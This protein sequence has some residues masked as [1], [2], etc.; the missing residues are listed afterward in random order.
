MKITAPRS[1]SGGPAARLTATISGLPGVAG[2]MDAWIEVPSGMAPAPGSQ[3]AGA[4]SSDASPWLVA[5]LPSAVSLQVPLEVEGRVSPRL[6]SG[7][8]KAMAVWRGWD[9][10]LRPVPIQAE[11]GSDEAPADGVGCFFSGGVDS[12]YSVL[13]AL[14][15]PRWS[16]PTHLIFCAGLD[17]PLRS[18]QLLGQIGSNLERIAEDL[19]LSFV[20]MAT[21]LRQITDPHAD[22]GRL[23]HGALLAALGLTLSPSLGRILIPAT[24]TYDTLF[25]WGSHPVVDPLW[26]SGATEFLHDGCEASRMEKILWRV[27]GS[28]PVLSGLRVCYKNPDEAYNCGECEKCVR[29]MVALEVAGVLKDCPTFERELTAEAVRRIDTS[30]AQA[31]RHA[32]DNLRAMKEAGVAPDL[33]EALSHALKR[34]RRLGP[35]AERGLRR[36]GLLRRR[37]RARLG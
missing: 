30:D 31:Y 22:W 29:T 5:M 16:D 19:G 33:Q 20:S 2:A 23:Q 32:M 8:E 7:I 25:P 9:R 13:R 6:L 12:S 35:L 10:R 14:D 15:D 3:A 36:A 34:R 27:A 1:E 18:T 24:N 21:N 37:L 17:V 26:S 4:W 28:K 11:V